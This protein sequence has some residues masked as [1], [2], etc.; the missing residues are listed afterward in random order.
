MVLAQLSGTAALFATIILFRSALN[1]YRIPLEQ[2]GV[3]YLIPPPTHVADAV[4]TSH[5]GAEASNGTVETI[6]GVILEDFWLDAS[7][8]E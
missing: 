5:R 1:R 2:V 8:E 6:D 4:L 3:E 7:H